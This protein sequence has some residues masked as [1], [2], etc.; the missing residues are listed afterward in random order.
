MGKR[1]A[2]A[3]GGE[4]A[5]AVRE[6]GVLDGDAAAAMPGEVA[7]LVIAEHG[8]DAAEVDFRGDP[9]ADRQRLAVGALEHFGVD[10]APGAAEW[11]VHAFSSAFG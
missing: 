6:H 7:A 9:V 8:L 2:I 10:L 11:R 4:V 3:V 5:I 1:I